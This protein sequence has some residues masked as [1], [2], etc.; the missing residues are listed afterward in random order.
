MSLLEQMPNSL[1]QKLSGVPNPDHFIVNVL[2][3]AVS[4][5]DDLQKRIAGVCGKYRSVATSSE[6]FALRKQAEVELE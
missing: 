4:D 3:N 1:K 6:D 2:E 5:R